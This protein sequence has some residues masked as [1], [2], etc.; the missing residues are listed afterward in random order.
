MRKRV[1]IL[2]NDLDT[3]GAERVVSIIL[4]ILYKRYD[5]TLFMMHNIIF[6][7]IPKGIDIVIVGDSKLSDS[8][9]LKLFRVPLL[10]LNY[11]RLS[12]GGI[13]IS[14]LSRSNYINILSKLFG[15]EIKAIVGERAM[16][17]LHYKSGIGGFINRLLIRY[18]YPK[19]DLIF[20]NSR[21]NAIDLKVN[22]G[23]ERGIE[24][25]YN[26][27]DIDNILKLKSE[28]LELKS[29]FNFVTVGRL[30][31]GK[32]H[33]LLIRAMVEVEGNL[34]IIGDGTLKE[35]LQELIESLNLEDRVYLVGKD[36]NPYR[37][38]AR[39]DIFLFSSNREGFPN[40]LVEALAS[41]VPIISTD[42]RSGPRE[43]LAPD[44][45]VNISLKDTIEVAKY[46]I[47]TPTE[48]LSRMVEAIKLLQNSSKLREQYRDKALNRAKEF[49][50]N[51]IIE[52]FINIIE[53]S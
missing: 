52:D 12:R 32:N 36:K 27:F 20:A 9:L 34:Y 40:V 7:D 29:G 37:Y 49:H 46:G 26:P 31:E 4:N 30:D 16:P 28:R 17:S 38:M 45:S 2:I 22:F 6:Y 41:G 42:C 53:N 23:I 14:F 33:Q 15:P 11:K 5:I 48:S 3:G 39:A 10:A 21:G 50:Q 8:G 25:I 1:S 19:S 24:V 43:I 47:L 44:S 51:R 35:K 18:L 13:S